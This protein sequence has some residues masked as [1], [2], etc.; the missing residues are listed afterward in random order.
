LLLRPDGNG[1]LSKRDGDR[2]GFPVFP[3]SGEMPDTKTGKME[4]FT[5]YREAGYFPDA[6]VN[7]LA[8]LGW[9]PSGNRELFTLNELVQEFSLERV[10]K[11]GAKFDPE[12]TRWFN[13]QY[14]RMRSDAELARAWMPEL[15]EKGIRADEKRVEAAVRLI[16]EKAV[17]V[18]DFWTLGSFLFVP[19]GAYDAEVVRKR[20]NE[21]TKSFISELKDAFSRLADFTAESAEACFKETAERLGVKTGEVMQ[22]FRVCLSGMAGGP[23]LFEMAAFL[24]KEE[25]VRRLEKALNTIK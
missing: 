14:L 18:N 12:K 13:Q 22:L 2:L 17:F 4:K 1:K 21:S 3:L 23:V 15:Q 9:H 6:F 20:W 16:K 11:S 19:P 25:A 8:L 24:G 5:G 7:L 10:S